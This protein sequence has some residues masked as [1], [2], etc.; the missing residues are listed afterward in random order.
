MAS[1][2]LLLLLLLLLPV[3]VHSHLAAQQSLLQYDTEPGSAQ[4]LHAACMPC[5][6]DAY[7]E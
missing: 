1:I 6:S 5:I 2:L 3:L 4:A 7:F